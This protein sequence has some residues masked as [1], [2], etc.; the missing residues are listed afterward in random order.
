MGR[1]R[2]PGIRSLHASPV[3]AAGRVYFTGRE[4]TTV[5]LVHGDVLQVLATQ[6]VNDRF[7]ASP[8]IAG[9][10]LFLRGKKRLYC[11]ADDV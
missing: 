5:V 10:Q 8:A 2:L 9:N 4:G 7:D 3:A 11:I 6:T 1:S